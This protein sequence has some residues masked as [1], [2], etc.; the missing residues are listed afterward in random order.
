[1]AFR[2][3]PACSTR[4]ET[5]EKQLRPLDLTKEIK[6]RVYLPRL[7]MSDAALIR[8]GIRGGDLERRARLKSARSPLTARGDARRYNASIIRPRS[9]PII[10]R[11]PRLCDSPQQSGLLSLV[12]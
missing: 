7:M 2:P 3:L 5:K 10:S 12:Q 11:G 6:K 8:A 4:L 9:L 1:M